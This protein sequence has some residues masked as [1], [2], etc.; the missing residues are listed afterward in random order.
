MFFQKKDM[1]RK[2]L[3]SLLRKNIEELEM[4][5]DG[6]MEMEEYP[7][8]IVLLAKR[9]TEDIQ[10]IIDE[11]G[12]IKAVSKESG[13][14][15]KNEPE[16]VEVIEQEVVSAVEETA[17]GEAMKVELLEEVDLQNNEPE[18]EIQEVIE[19]AKPEPVIEE[20]KVQVELIVPIVKAEP[21]IKV[22]EP[23]AE[24]AEPKK[25]TIAEKVGHQTTSRNE[26]L[27]RGD[28]SL[29][30]TLANKK[31]SDIKQAISI[32]DRFRFQREL[33]KSNG[34]DMNKTLTYIN[35]LAT[36]KEAIDF[37]NSKYNWDETNEAVDDFYQIV[38]RKFV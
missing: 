22:A 38:K 30:A 34:E 2:L 7:A 16:T 11:L 32:G 27:S 26:L 14:T 13:Q 37:L 6:F 17:E 23:K 28:N 31:I 4:I 21:E 8:A 15:L 24:I 12:A 9:K 5:T 29:G 20:P 3:V 18:P 25:V 19:I 36:L 35:Q 33:F 1:N 10:T